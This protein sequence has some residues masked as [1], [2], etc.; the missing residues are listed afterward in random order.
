MALAETGDLEHA[1]S[2]IAEALEQA[3]SHGRA[4]LVPRLEQSRVTLER[5]EAIRSPWPAERFG[6]LAGG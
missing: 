3:R 1:R 6:W 4:E 2:R 5:G